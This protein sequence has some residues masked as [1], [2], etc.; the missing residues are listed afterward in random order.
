[1]LQRSNELN[2]MR[3]PAR[4]GG[5]ALV[6]CGL[7][8]VMWAQQNNHR[9]SAAERE[10]I[11][12][13][14]LKLISTTEDIPPTLKDAFSQL[15][16]QPSFAMAD[17]AQKYQVGDVVVDRNL[18]FRRLVLAGVGDDKWFIHYEKGGRGRTYYVVLFKIDQHGGAH[19]L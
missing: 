9:L 3:V 16:R 14:Q 15:S 1:M 12:D 8:G 4:H 13:G 17:P 10:H 19:F 2:E 18:P 5:V 6:L 11:L 7:S